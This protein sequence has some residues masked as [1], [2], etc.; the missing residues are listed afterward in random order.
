PDHHHSYPGGLAVHE[1]FNLQSAL[2]LEA[3]FRARYAMEVDDDAVIAAPILHDA[4]K[5]WVLQWTADGSLTEQAT[6]AGTPSHHVFGIAESL[7]RGMPAPLVLAQ[8][9]AH[10][11][12]AAMDPGPIARWLRAGALLAR[13]DPVAAGLL[14]SSGALAL[15]PPIEAVIDHLSDHDYVLEDP[16]G[17]E[18]AAA[19][20][21]LAR[22]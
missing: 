12:F 5:A 21:R 14:T 7:H 6:I 11:P 4:M 3:N 9:A 10:D 13:V 18:V 16:A 15:R 22:A 8:A 20:A 17:A 19:L 1:A 2:D